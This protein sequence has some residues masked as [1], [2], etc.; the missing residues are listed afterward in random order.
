MTG[1]YAKALQT[2]N[3]ESYLKYRCPKNNCLPKEMFE[4]DKKY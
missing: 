1:Q 4:R 2:R 3:T